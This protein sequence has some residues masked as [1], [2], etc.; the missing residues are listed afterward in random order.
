MGQPRRRRRK[1]EARRRKDADRLEEKWEQRRAQQQ[2]AERDSGGSSPALPAGESN[3]SPE[4][5]RPPPAMVEPV[6]AMQAQLQQV[7]AENAELKQRQEKLLQEKLEEKLLQEKFRKAASH[8]RK[9]CVNNGWVS[10]WVLE[11]PVDATC[12]TGASAKRPVAEGALG[13]EAKR[14]QSCASLC[15]SCAACGPSC[16]SV[17]H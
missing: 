4:D 10:P 17:G 1:S 6:S 16:S 9:L 15:A 13:R 12:E 7:M 3:C 2:V 11:Q 8:Y 5:H 14:C